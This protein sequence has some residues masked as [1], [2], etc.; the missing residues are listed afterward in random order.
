MPS[1]LLQWTFDSNTQSWI[2]SSGLA[3]QWDGSDGSPTAG[4][5]YR[6][7]S[8]N[9]Y[10]FTD[11]FQSPVIDW[12]SLLPV[13]P[14][15]VTSIRM[16]AMIKFVDNDGRLQNSSFQLYCTIGGVEVTGPSHGNPNG[17]IP[18]T[19]ITDT[20]PMNLSSLGTGRMQVGFGGRISGGG[21]RSATPYT[22]TIEVE[23]F[24]ESYDKEGSVIISE[25][26]NISLTGEKYEPKHATGT[27]TISEKTN[28]NM[29]TDSWQ[30]P[31][32]DIVIS[33]KTKI[34]ISST[35]KF[36]GSGD[37]DPQYHPQIYKFPDDMEGWFVEGAGNVT[38]NSNVYNGYGA[39]MYE[40]TGNVIE[41]RSPTM[42]LED[43][44]FPVG[45][46]CDRGTIEYIW[47]A[48]GFV[49][50]GTSMSINL[51][52]WTS[53]GYGYGINRTVGTSSIWQVYSINRTASTNT[54]QSDTPFHF[55]LS[56]SS[57]IGEFVSFTHVG[58]TMTVLVPVEE[59]S[60]KVYK[61]LTISEPTNVTVTGTKPQEGDHY[62][63]ILTITEPVTLIK[64][65]TKATDS[66]LTITE[67][68]QLLILS[69]KEI[70]GP[71]VL[72]SYLRVLKT[73][74]K[75]SDFSGI[76][77]N[78]ANLTKS[79]EK[80]TLKDILISEGSSLN[81]T[82]YKY[83]ITEGQ[84]LIL[85][86]NGYNIS[87]QGQK[88]IRAPTEISGPTNQLTESTKRIDHDLTITESGNFIATGRDD[89]TVDF[90]SD[91]LITTKVNLLTVSSKSMTAQSTITTGS[92]L[93]MDASKG[94]Q[95]EQVI[96]EG[97]G[98]VMDGSK[99]STDAVTIE[100]KVVIS[101]TGQDSTDHDKDTGVVISEPTDVVVVSGK[102]HSKALIL[103]TSVHH[104]T[105]GNKGSGVGVTISTPVT[106]LSSYRLPYTLLT[107]YLTITEADTNVTMTEHA[108]AL[109]VT[110]RSFNIG[111]EPFPVTLSVI[112]QEATTEVIVLVLSKNT[113]RLK[114]EFK[115]FD[116]NLVSPEDVVLRIY[117]WD[118]EQIGNPIPVNPI[119]I[120]VFQYDYTVPDTPNNALY[121]EFQGTIGG[122]PVVARDIMTVKWV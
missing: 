55:R 3:V 104:T 43:L 86:S 32:A 57:P 27:V 108:T 1:L 122:N 33:E 35:V 109:T 88:R 45:S 58:S 103:T 21:G 72:E 110:E 11:R 37:G 80:G 75:G 26:V 52:L 8:G 119:D 10:T 13:G 24:Y 44:G 9:N 95:M 51:V 22:D 42:T 18:W 76:I 4:S 81:V 66:I 6:T 71:M 83:E 96:G 101:V 118:R 102:G 65:G 12:A 15:A 41:A 19:Q 79:G 98:L 121:F 36:E 50:S 94:I 82:Y 87:I 64:S 85:I 74:L 17:P 97:S 20:I 78:P 120:G 46:F 59:S 106:I 112:N 73:A 115:D 28:I 47:R 92:D 69:Q 107:A 99:S 38:Y 84:G 114:A 67:P 90:F 117:T 77:E 56:V 16:K 49:P 14:E 5:I 68:S 34:K 93:T 116:G 25:P 89:S 91:I 53:A 70:Q 39:I 61:H 29:T 54:L 48:W 30:P 113:V 111:H 105:S 62:S 100:S 7:Y 40:G 63:S 31:K 23:V 60:H 2:L